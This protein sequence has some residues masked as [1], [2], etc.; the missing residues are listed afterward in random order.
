MM[1]N[2]YSKRKGYGQ[3]DASLG[4]ICLHVQPIHL[5]IQNSQQESINPFVSMQTTTGRLPNDLEGKVEEIHD[6]LCDGE[7]PLKSMHLSPFVPSIIFGRM[8]K[9]LKIFLR[10]PSRTLEKTRHFFFFLV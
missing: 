5:Y 8:P 9:S 4:H 3:V 1:T 2:P 7:T 10:P 6:N